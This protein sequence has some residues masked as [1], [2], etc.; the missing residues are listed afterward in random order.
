MHLPTTS[1]APSA[2]ASRVCAKS[3]SHSFWREA[4]VE[5]D[6]RMSAPS[7]TGCMAATRTVS[8]LSG[9]VAYWMRLTVFSPTVPK[10]AKQDA[11]AR[12]LSWNSVFL[13]IRLETAVYSTTGACDVVL[14]AVVMGGADQ[15]VRR[16]ADRSRL[17]FSVCRRPHRSRGSPLLRI[18]GFLSGWLPRLGAV[19]FRTVASVPPRHFLARS[20]PRVVAS[21]PP[22]T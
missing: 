2:A 6:P 11:L 18:L 10:R 9:I 8:G 14:G 1:C 3:V 12:F 15:A 7:V 13:L 19:F 4:S 17:C 21:I 5:L 22:R 20:S 16:D